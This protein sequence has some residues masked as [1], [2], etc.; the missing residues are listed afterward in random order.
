MYCDQ[1]V[2]GEPYLSVVESHHWALKYVVNSW[3]WMTFNESFLGHETYYHPYHANRLCCLQTEMPAMNMFRYNLSAT[4]YHLHGVVIPMR[5]VT[6]NYQYKCCQSLSNLRGIGLFHITSNWCV[7]HGFDESMCLKSKSHIAEILC[8]KVH[9][10]FT[11]NQDPTFARHATLL[12]I[13]V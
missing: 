10:K 8:T 6:V 1:A 3:H 7:K 11:L 4:S 5:D 2:V 12:T 9:Q 13:M